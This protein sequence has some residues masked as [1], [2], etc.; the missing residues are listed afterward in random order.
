MNEA[1]NRDLKIIFSSVLLAALL[2][3]VGILI[4]RAFLPDSGSR[5]TVSP[6]Y[7]SPSVVQ[8][9]S[10]EQHAGTDI[11]GFESMTF[12]A[13]SQAQAV[14]LENPAGNNC[15]MVFS[16]YLPDGRK[17]YQSGYVE[18]GRYVDQIFLDMIPDVGRYENAVLQYDC[19]AL[20]DATQAQNSAKVEFLLEVVK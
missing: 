7:D 1:K 14:K 19:Y 15:Y 20:D 10:S 12:K 9:E 16:I 5:A 3:V 13:G 4:G 11:P 8:D 6:A 2:L 17:I 18:P